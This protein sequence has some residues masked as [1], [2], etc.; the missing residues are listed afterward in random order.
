MNEDVSLVPC[1]HGRGG[2]H[3]CETGS[4]EAPRPTVWQPRGHPAAAV[5]VSRVPRSVLAVTCVGFARSW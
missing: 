4:R 3:L 2:G 1:R 5:I